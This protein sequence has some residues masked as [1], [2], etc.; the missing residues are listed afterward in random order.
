LAGRR[1]GKLHRWRERSQGL[2]SFAIVR[3]DQFSDD[4][5]NLSNIEDWITIKKVVASKELA[6]TEVARLNGLVEKRDQTR[7][8]YFAQHTRLALDE[9]SS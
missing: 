9:G 3:V 5:L 6:D 4:L 1:S 2:P 8:R 7:I